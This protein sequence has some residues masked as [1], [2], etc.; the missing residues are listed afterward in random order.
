M[1][2]TARSEVNIAI[3]ILRNKWFFV[4]YS[5]FWIVAVVAVSYSTVHWAWRALATLS[6]VFLTPTLKEIL[7]AFRASRNRTKAT[8]PPPE[9]KSD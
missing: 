2:P 7:D 3:R 1:T 4:A 8:K 5:V 6:L 9:L